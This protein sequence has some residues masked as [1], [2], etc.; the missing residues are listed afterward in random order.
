MIADAGSLLT[1]LALDLT[2]DCH[3]LDLCA[4]PGTKFMTMMQTFLPG[5]ENVSSTNVFWCKAFVSNTHLFEFSAGAKL[6]GG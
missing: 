1:V 5:N 6:I 4:A 2:P 3:V